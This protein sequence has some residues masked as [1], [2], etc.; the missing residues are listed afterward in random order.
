MDSPATGLGGLIIV[1]LIALGLFFMLRSIMLWYWKVDTIVKNQEEQK[2]LMKEQRDF[3]EQIYL[4][5]G[6]HKIKHSTDSAE[7][8]ARKAK[9]FDETK[10]K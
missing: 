7:E 2:S 10:N 4:L 5:Q 6:G 9:L 8:I 1:L 3:L